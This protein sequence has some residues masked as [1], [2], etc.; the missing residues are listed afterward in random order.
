MKTNENYAV[1]QR[2]Y[3]EYG[4]FKDT[5]ANTPI[6]VVNHKFTMLLFFREMTDN[7]A[8][9]PM[10]VKEGGM[11]AYMVDFQGMLDGLDNPS[12]LKGEGVG[13]CAGDDLVVRESN[14]MGRDGGTK[15]AKLSQY[16]CQGFN[17]FL[18]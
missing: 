11:R 5:H 3:G 16:P 18:S 13:A 9:I 14:V 12:E 7:I 6:T 10:E 1:I 2:E 8:Q 17:P 4:S 15:G